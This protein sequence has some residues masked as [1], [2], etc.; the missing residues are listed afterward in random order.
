MHDGWWQVST[1]GGRRAV[2]ARDGGELFYIDSTDTLTAVP[3]QTTAAKFAWG[4]P[5]RLIKLAQGSSQRFLPD[6]DVGLDGRFLMI[7]EQAAEGQDAAAPRM[8]VHLKFFEDL[9]RLVPTN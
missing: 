8:V 1:G 6:Y 5:V 9:K 2:W 7:K 3:V 4:N